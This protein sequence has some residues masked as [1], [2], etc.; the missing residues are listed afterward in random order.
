MPK[1]SVIIP[2][3]NHACFIGEAVESVLMQT[4]Q[5]LEL[6]IVDDGSTDDTLSVL[7]RF[8]D[9]RMRVIPQA[10]KGAYAAL[11]RGL[12]EAN[13][14]YLAILNSDDVYHPRRLE[15]LIAKLE[16]GTHMGLIG[17]YIEVID[18]QGKPLGVKK[19]YHNLEPWVLPNRDKSFRATDDVRGVL[20]TENFYATTSNFVFHRELFERIG[21]FRPLRYTH[22]WDFL[23]R[24]ALLARLEMYPEPL[25]KYRLHSRN[26]IRE[27]TPW[28]VFEICWCIAMHLPKHL[29]DL[30][31]FEQSSQ[32]LK[33]ERLLYSIYVFGC[34]KVLALMFLRRLQKGEKWALDL[35]RPDNPERKVYLDFI[36]QCI[37]RHK[38]SQNEGAFSFKRLLNGL[39]EEVRQ[40]VWRL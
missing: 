5:D 29:E 26:T 21:G 8:S 40:K 9:S 3:Y 33:L 7:E 31:W 30:S 39:W 28:M 18:A 19:S 27:N 1:V 34:E 38:R 22:D 24:S 6:I 2:S 14:R 20:L 16:R 10:H 13:G 12:K 36:A 35:L 37:K 17:S 4:E 11:N 15:K 32:M 23:L 25:L